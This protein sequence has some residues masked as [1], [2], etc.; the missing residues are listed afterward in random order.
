[1]IEDI[2]LRV[3]I[4]NG[5]IYDFT[6]IVTNIVWSGDYR[7]PS[8][9]L[10][11]SYLRPVNDSNIPQK[12]VLINST[13]CFYVDSVEIFRG[14]CVDIDK[15]SSSNIT[16]MTFKDIGYILSTD[17]KNYN[18][19]NVR[20]DEAVK[21][22]F[23]ENKPSIPY[24]YIAPCNSKITQMYIGKTGYEIIMDIYT[25]HSK[26]GGGK[27]K[28]MIKVSLDKMSIIEKGVHTIN[29]EFRES[30]NIINTS[31]KQN[32]ND[33]TNRVVVVDE[34]GN[35]TYEKVNNELMKIYNRYATEVIQSNK[36]NKVSSSEIAN[37]FKDMQKTCSLTGFGNINA[38]TGCKVSVRDKHTGLVGIFYVDK[39]THTWQG[40]KHTIELE[41]NFENLM[42]EHT[43]EKEETATS[44]NSSSASGSNMSNTKQQIIV[45]SALS[46][47][48]S[49]YVWGAKGPT[50]FDCS[51]F[52]Y[53]AHKQA[54]ITIGGASAAQLSSGKGVKSNNILP[55]DI[56][57]TRSS[58]S[59]SGRHVKIYI[60]DGYC[61]EA[62]SP[63][64]GVIKSKLN[65]GNGLLGIRRCWE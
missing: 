18:F 7:S 28:Y 44:S 45:K 5:K 60:G 35:K 49:R 48:G 43:E 20:G 33:F 14:N 27:W 59:P 22:I 12:D 32:I 30:E 11:V 39:D 62:A 41:L 57:I 17:K 42:D 61:V 3:H 31:Y 38:I 55:G 19:N 53:W 24:S 37:A 8:R 46:K 52:A 4:K 2:I 40:G 58:G 23:K 29:I 36:E 26:N 21:K 9:T 56:I 50:S 10:E 1:M 65:F 6:N 25:K 47:L 51:G 34:K 15:D 64:Q 54:G 63:R 13:C 16:T